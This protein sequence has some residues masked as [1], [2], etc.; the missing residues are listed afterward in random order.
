VLKPAH[1]LYGELLAAAGKCDEA[2]EA[3]R[4]SLLRTPNRRLSLVTPACR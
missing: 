2:R 3:Y 4:K 1:E